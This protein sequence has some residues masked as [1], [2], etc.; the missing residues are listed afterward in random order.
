VAGSWRAQ[1]GLVSAALMAVA[2]RPRLWPVA[3]REARRLAPTGWWRRPPFLPLP[4]AA[5]RR[6]RMET[7]YGADDHLPVPDDLVRWLEWCRS[8]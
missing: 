5:Y 4:P 8:H 3:V 1:I 7:M 6:F 2:G